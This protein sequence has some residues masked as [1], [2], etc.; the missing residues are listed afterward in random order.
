[1]ELKMDLVKYNKWKHQNGAE[2]MNNY[3]GAVF[4]YAEQWA[5]LMEQEIEDKDTN[6]IIFHKILT[7]QEQYSHDADKEGI[8]G[9]QYGMARSILRQCWKHGDLLDQALQINDWKTRWEIRHKQ[10]EEE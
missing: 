4:R 2:D 6:I 5:E 10:E 9:A 3:G 8:T 7:C 1:M